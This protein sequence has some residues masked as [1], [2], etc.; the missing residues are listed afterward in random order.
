MSVRQS[1]RG[2]AIGTA[3]L[4]IRG[5]DMKNVVRILNVALQTVCDT[6]TTLTLSRNLD[7]WV[8]VAV[9]HILKV[10]KLAEIF[11]LEV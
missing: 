1:I 7:Y 2:D 4:H 10:S 9:I 8:W 3:S 5:L 6:K 11:P